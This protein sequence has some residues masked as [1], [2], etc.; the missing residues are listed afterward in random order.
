LHQTTIGAVRNRL[1]ASLYD[2]TNEISRNLANAAT[3][4][5][6]SPESVAGVAEAIASKRTCRQRRILIFTNGASVL[7]HDDDNFPGEYGLPDSR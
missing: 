1:L 6:G 7:E 5:N 4:G 2:T 3:G